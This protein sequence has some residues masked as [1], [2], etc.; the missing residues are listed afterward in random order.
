M[1]YNKFASA[2]FFWIA[3]GSLYSP[4]GSAEGESLTAWDPT[5]TIQVTVRVSAIE[6][7]AKEEVVITASASDTDTWTK[8]I[9]GQSDGA[10][11]EAN[12]LGSGMEPDKCTMLWEKRGGRWGSVTPTRRV[13]KAPNEP[14]IYTITL[15]VDD[16]APVVDMGSRDDAAV[17][18][19][20]NIKVKAE[21]G[22]QPL[23]KGQDC[24]DTVFPASPFYPDKECCELAGVLDKF[25]IQ[26]LSD[27]PHRVSRHG[28]RVV[29]NGCSAEILQVFGV[30][31]INNPAQGKDTQFGNLVNRP[32][33]F[34]DLCWGTCGGGGDPLNYKNNCDSAF[35]Y[36][37]LGVCASSKESAAVKRRCERSARVYYVGVQ[38]FFA[39]DFYYIPG[40]KN[41]CQ[42][43][44]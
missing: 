16:T 15:T 44:E 2:C 33:D 28:Y 19:T 12:L 34:H 25:N 35:L 43:C 4:H 1:L 30:P 37:M 11:S 10:M 24:C 31:D 9:P 7:S 32:C 38:N 22:D 14:G 27:C 20:F 29:S 17:V 41:A 42:C 23:K 21:C 5:P 3:L 18:K 39:R 6:I 13:W 36:G 40:Q 26:K 8:Y